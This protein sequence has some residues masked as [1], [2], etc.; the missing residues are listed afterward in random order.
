MTGLSVLA[1]G[2][3][4]GVRHALEADH[5]AAVATLVEEGTDRPGI[6]GA[7]WG[8][9]HSLPIALLGLLAVSLG[10]RPPAVVTRLL[11]GVVGLV[12]VFLGLRVLWR[13]SRARLLAEHDHAGHAHAHRNLGVGPL[14]VGLAHHHLDGE[15]LLVG[16]LHGV[17]GSGALVVLLVA[18]TPSFEAAVGFLLAFCLLTLGTMAAIGALWGRTLGTGAAPYL[19]GAAGVLGVAIGA[20]LLVGQV[21]GPPAF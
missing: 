4:L 15:S 13:V 14:S 7:S 17:A 2:A 16:V 5:L 3:V 21:V 9:G 6:V 18:A 8:V 19:K 10:V 12:L 1:A 11:E 20:T